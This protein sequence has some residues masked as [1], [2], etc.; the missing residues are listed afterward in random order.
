MAFDWIRS[1]LFTGFPWLYLAHSQA[2]WTA[3]VQVSDVVG[4][5]GVTALVVLVN[6]AIV[7]TGLRLREGRAVA[8]RTPALVT[9]PIVA[10]V[11][12]YGYWRPGGV[13]VEKGPSVLLVQGNV[14]QRDK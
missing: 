6:A 12:G 3:L 9:V 8:A 11:L 4:T 2:D 13:E 1:W 7:E 5:Y 10:A 14:S